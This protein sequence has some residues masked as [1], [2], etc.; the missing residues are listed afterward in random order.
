ML[1]YVTSEYLE[2]ERVCLSCQAQMILVRSSENMGIII[3]IKNNNNKQK[4]TIVTT[5]PTYSTV[6]QSSEETV[7]FYEFNIKT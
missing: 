6:S 5:K 7:D 4:T 1:C 2:G 3:F